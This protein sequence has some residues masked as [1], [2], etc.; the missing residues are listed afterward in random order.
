M[1]PAGPAATGGSAASNYKT[2][3][4]TK[5]IEMAA[6]S[7]RLPEGAVFHSDPRE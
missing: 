5:A 7:V 6:R 3:F 2:S 1:T 4:I